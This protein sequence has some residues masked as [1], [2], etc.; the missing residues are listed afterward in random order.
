MKQT[1]IESLQEAIKLARAIVSDIALYQENKIKL[2]FKNDNLFNDLDEEIKEG[3]KLYKSR[4][5]SEIVEEQ[6]C[7]N[8]ALIDLVFKDIGKQIA[9]PI[10]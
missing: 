1:K 5:A 3:Y 8:R 4:V 10:W 6:N 9:S 7:Y 2:G